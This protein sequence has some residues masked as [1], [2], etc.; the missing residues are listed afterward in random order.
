MVMKKLAFGGIKA[1]M[2]GGLIAGNAALLGSTG[3]ASDNG[4]KSMERGCHSEKGCKGAKGC[5]GEKGCGGDKGAKGEK[6][7]GGKK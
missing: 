4:H 2:V 6:G 5:G 3:C 7:C 1:A